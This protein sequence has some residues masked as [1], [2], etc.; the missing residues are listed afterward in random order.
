VS[1]PPPELERLDS[2]LGGARI[3]HEAI[4]ELRRELLAQGRGDAEHAD[5]LT[6]SAQIAVE[7]LPSLTARARELSGKWHE[8]SLLDPEAAALT[9]GELGAELARLEPRARPLLQRQR[10]IAALFRGELGP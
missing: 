3:A 7:E 4:F 8:Q 2:L 10:Q 1:K 9:L 6:E 5:L